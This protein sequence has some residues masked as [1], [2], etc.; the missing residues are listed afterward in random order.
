LDMSGL[1]EKHLGNLLEPQVL[2]RG[3]IVEGS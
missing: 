3:G 2:T 1:P